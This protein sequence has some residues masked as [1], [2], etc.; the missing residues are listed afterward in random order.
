MRISDWSSDLCSSDLT[1]RAEGA[2]NLPISDVVSL[3]LA[4]QS[5]DQ[6]KGFGRNT[7]LDEDIADQHAHNFRAQLLVNPTDALEVLVSANY[8]KVDDHRDR[9]STRLNSSH[10]CA[11]RMPSSA[12]NKKKHT[13]HNRTIRVHTP[14]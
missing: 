6:N 4:A 2:V 7:L 14:Q 10:S 1:I 3:R 11:S 12:C 9:K 5:I 13:T 8:S